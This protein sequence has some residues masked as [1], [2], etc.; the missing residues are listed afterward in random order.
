MWRIRK[1]KWKISDKKGHE[2]YDDADDDDDDEKKVTR[3]PARPWRKFG[4]DVS[5]SI[6]GRST[7]V[8]SEGTFL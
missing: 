4:L 3:L 2:A 6:S 1:S 8:K 7:T 5:A